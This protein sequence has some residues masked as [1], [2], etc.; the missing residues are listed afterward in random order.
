[1]EPGSLVTEDGVVLP[2]RPSEAELRPLYEIG[3]RPSVRLSM[4]QA[5]D[6]GA[7]GIDGKS[8]TLNGPEDLRVLK[9]TRSWADVVIIG[10]R[11]ARIEGYGN[12]R[13]GPELTAAREASGFSRLPDLALITRS[14]RVP[15]GLDPTRTWI[16][17]TEAGHAAVMG[18]PLASRVF[19]VG[20]EA[21]DATAIVATLWDAG[22][23]RML[24]EGG[25]AVAEMF[26][27]ANLVSDFCLT[28]SPHPSGP[29]PVVPPVPASLRRE[30]VLTGNGYTMERWSQPQAY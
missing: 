29:G 15:D 7:V 25:P 1:M 22:R 21:V 10:A 3:D 17:T 4:I 26:I 16:F 12:I 13:L 20:T 14:G 23:R 9:V 8:G 18:G 24:C 28:T 11:T 27:D 19:T 5:P 6:H 2:P 30:L